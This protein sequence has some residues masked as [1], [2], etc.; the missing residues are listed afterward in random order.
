LI[1]ASGCQAS[2]RPPAKKTIRQFP[3]ARIGNLNFWLTHLYIT[4]ARA[5]VSTGDCLEPY[6]TVGP[7]HLGS[8]LAF[9]LYFSAVSSSF[10]RVCLRG[11]ELLRQGEL[12][13]VLYRC[14]LDCVLQPRRPQNT[15]ARL[16]NLRRRIPNFLEGYCRVFRF[17]SA[18]ECPIKSPTRS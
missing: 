16:T 15:R 8:G 1:L 12:G 6:A 3:A 14:C 17:P 10:T 9:R 2:S 18:Y 7:G 5:V 4:W 11:G 13:E